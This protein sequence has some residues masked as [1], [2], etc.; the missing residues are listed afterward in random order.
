MSSPVKKLER[1]PE[2]VA[3]VPDGN[4][5]WAEKQGL[6]RLAGHQ[7]G[8]NNMHRIV[9]YL[10]EYPIKYITLYGF[11][12]ENWKRTEKEISYLMQLFET[13][14]INKMGEFN[15]LGIQMRIL[16]DLDKL[17]I[18][19][20]KSLRNAE[21]LTKK[22]EKMIVNIALNYGGRQELVRAFQKLLLANVSAIE[23]TEN[24]ININLDTAGLP[25][26]D[27]IIRTSGEQRLSNFLPWQAIYSEL[28]FT[29][30]LWPDFD[31]QKLDIALEEF[32]RRQ[33]RIGK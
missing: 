2:H 21:M 26:P 10:S 28:Y 13:Y 1:Y 8:A 24:L 31:R 30:V 20:Q 11:S 22:N 32:Q 7:A 9:Q 33:R 25:D 16:G 6:P 12:T 23:I 14:T 27:L 29:K 17:P 19:L 15:D 4:G 18:S 3:I 5:R